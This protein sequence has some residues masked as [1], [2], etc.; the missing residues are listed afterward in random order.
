MIPSSYDQGFA[1][2]VKACLLLL[3][4]GTALCGL[5]ILFDSDDAIEC[6][7]VIGKLRRC[8]DEYEYV[9]NPPVNLPEGHGDRE[10]QTTLSTIA[11]S[12]PQVVLP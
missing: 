1:I 7:T 2:G 8:L 4:A 10:R 9:T 12:V 6:Q 11:R 5:V 3:Q